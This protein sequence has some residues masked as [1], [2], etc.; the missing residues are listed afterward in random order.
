MKRTGQGASLSRAFTDISCDP[1]Y[2][3]G[4]AIRFCCS[5]ARRRIPRVR[6][7]SGFL[8][9]QPSSCVMWARRS[10][11]VDE[12]IAFQR[13]RVGGELDLH[14]VAAGRAPAVRREIA[15][16]AQQIPVG[17]LIFERHSRER[18]DAVR[19]RD[20]EQIAVFADQ[21]AAGHREHGCAD[22][23][24]AGHGLVDHDGVDVFRRT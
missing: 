11:S 8:R 3:L 21:R 19:V 10:R 5:S 23:R 9:S 13:L 12:D 22:V 14:A 15:D 16:H 1:R 18:Q 17:I 2:V 7:K 6:Q 24:V 20:L 4:C